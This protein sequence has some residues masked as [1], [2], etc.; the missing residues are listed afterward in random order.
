MV[1]LKSNFL[2]LML[3]IVSVTNATA[4]ET[5]NFFD[6]Y[7]LERVIDGDTIVASGLKIRLWGIDAPE[8]GDAL[9]R[10]ST[11]YLETILSE[12]GLTCKFIELDR[13]SRSVMHCSVRGADIGSIM[14]QMGMAKDYTRYS[15]GFYQEEQAEAK[16]EL[17]G[18]WTP[19]N[20]QKADKKH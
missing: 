8:H 4:K 7:N 6:P 12:G 11:L 1:D 9:Y 19:G 15:G 17:R 13:Y 2:V 18:I 5:Q 20:Q 3:L 14:V 16:R 10:V